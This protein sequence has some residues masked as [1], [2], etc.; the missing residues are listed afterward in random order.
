MTD[1]LYKCAPPSRHL[2]TLNLQ[3]LCVRLRLHCLQLIVPPWCI[4]TPILD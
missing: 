2:F 1:A 4:K 3:S